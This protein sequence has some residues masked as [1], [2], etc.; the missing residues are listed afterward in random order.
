MELCLPEITSFL[1]IQLKFT[2]MFSIYENKVK[3]ICITN[4]INYIFCLASTFSYYQLT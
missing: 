4:F 3:T 2:H 1:I